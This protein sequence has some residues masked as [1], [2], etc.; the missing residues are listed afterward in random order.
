MIAD[1]Q[2]FANLVKGS[3]KAVIWVIWM[4]DKVTSQNG[5]MYVK[6]ISSTTENKHVS[7]KNWRLVA[8]SHLGR[9]D[10]K[11]QLCFGVPCLLVGGVREA[12]NEDGEVRTE[13]PENWK[14]WRQFFPIANML[15][16]AAP[17]FVVKTRQPGW[18]YGSWIWLSLF[19]PDEICF[20]QKN[21]SLL[22][23]ISSNLSPF[24]RWAPHKFW[25]ACGSTP[26]W[27]PREIAGKG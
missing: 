13:N 22:F 8:T 9:K 16:L 26:W 25:E 19:N 27:L 2:F 14:K 10:P 17:V 23:C 20:I 6:I 15:D 4:K 7:L 1:E 12:V 5:F 21:T 18:F 11:C 3:F 24:I